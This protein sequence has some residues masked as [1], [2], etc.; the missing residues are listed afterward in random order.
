MVTKLIKNIDL[1]VTMDDQRREIP[2]GGLF[3]RDG[4]IEQVGKTSELPETANEVI[5]LSGHIVLPGM[6]NTHHHFFQTLTRAVPA[7]QDANLF[8]WLKTLYPIWAR[9]QPEDIYISTIT[10]LAEYA[11][12]HIQEKVQ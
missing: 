11:M 7:A 9:M 2:S 8:N 5:D 6:I 4:I 3:I 12:S 1:L 10:A